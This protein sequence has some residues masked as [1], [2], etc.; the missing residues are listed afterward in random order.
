MKKKL[1][2]YPGSFN[3]FHKGHLEILKK[4]EAIF[5]EVIVAIGTNP[6][7]KID[8]KINRLET[9]RFQLPGKKVEQ[10]SGFLS[11]YVQD[12]EDEGYNVTIV[13]GL[14]N[15][16][17]LNYETNQLR[18]MLDQKPDLKM[19]FIPCD[20][21]F[22]HVS[23]SMI[24]AMEKIQ[25]GSASE[26]IVKPEMFEDPNDEYA[27]KQI[28]EAYGKPK[29]LTFEDFR[30]EATKI[31]NDIKIISAQSDLFRK[32]YRRLHKLC[33]KCGS[34]KYSTTLVGYPLVV[35]EEEKYKDLNNCK[36]LGCGDKHTVHE[37]KEQF[38]KDEFVVYFED[39]DPDSGDVSQTKVVAN[40]KS[41][42][43][44]KEITKHFNAFDDAG[45]GSRTYKYK[46]NN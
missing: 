15:G 22:E 44:A 3:P 38:L 7:K 43:F 8:E 28:Y 12:K 32:E 39:I 1:A 21:R 42:T 2:I 41:E 26:Y 16:A 9:L 29:G 10:F 40:V 45:D 24:R 36:C 5:D 33:P 20:V 30:E 17:D 34:D 6:D 13:R 11:D 23:S 46:K 25:E 19:I 37:R 14:R 18:V 27:K 4:A 31:L 35:G